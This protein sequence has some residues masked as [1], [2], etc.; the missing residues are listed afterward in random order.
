MQNLNTANN[1]GIKVISNHPNG[2]YGSVLIGVSVNLDT[3]NSNTFDS[4]FQNMEQT[5][6][7]HE[8]SNTRGKVF[9]NENKFTIDLGFNT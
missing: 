6:R 2:S 3:L 5:K 9:N 7:E 4:H 8:T 1:S